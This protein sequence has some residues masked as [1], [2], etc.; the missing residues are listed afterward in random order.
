MKTEPSA[1][2]SA[3]ADIL[4]IEPGELTEATGVGSIAEWDSLAQLAI[5]TT[6]EDEFGLK[7][8]EER[9]ME[10]S[11]VGKILAFVCDE[12]AQAAK[13]PSSISTTKVEAAPPR[14]R[15]ST[16]RS[17][18]TQ[19]IVSSILDRID[20]HPSKVALVFDTESITY[21]Q[22][23]TGMRAA[24]NYLQ[25]KGVCAGDV[26]GL[27]A[28]KQK[29]FFFCY[30]GA[31]LLGATVLNLNPAIKDELLSY[32]QEQT[33]PKL[34]IGSGKGAELSYAEIP[35]H[36]FDQ[37]ATMVSPSMDSVAEIMFTTGT[38]HLPKGVLITHANQAAFT[39]INPY[40]DI[41][42][43]DI[44]LI[45]LPLHHVFGIGMVFRLL[46]TGGT[47]IIARSISNL[48]QIFTSLRDYK[49]TGVAM[50]ASGWMYIRRM[51]GNSVGEFAP[52]LRHMIMA[53]MPVSL[54]LR[55]YL[56]RIFPH[57]RVCV[58]YG[59]TEATMSTIID[60]STETEHPDS[61][62]RG[63]P[64]VEIKICAEDGTELPRGEK[65][66][67]C[68]K[69]PNVM[70]GYLRDQGPG[71]HHG[72]F[73]RSGDWGCMDADG[74]V[75]IIGRAKDIINIGGENV[76]P[77][78]I[79]NVLNTIPGILESACVPTPDPQGIL[80]EV[81]KAIL[82]SDGSTPKPTN[83]QIIASAAKQ[84]DR[85]KLPVV[86]EW[87]EALTRTETGKIQRQLMR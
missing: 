85:F 51:S 80:G 39:L 19:P 27:Y 55:D 81:V 22:L 16:A 83:E 68:I 34:I 71:T 44:E 56:M 86:I 60:L 13:A 23:A 73:L 64:G 59:L 47:A 50:P 76:S 9:M 67:I 66:E 18:E 12:P 36:D 5:V 28:D 17:Y 78:E 20:T 75:Y 72:E 14:G 31:H 6:L 58:A 37:T 26:V 54:E 77:H 2:L 65:G 63:S 45:V 33:N 49:A 8:P 24:A 30:F 53:S 32:V 29:E 57:A 74:Y 69:G 70:K 10:L 38:T 40:V 61:I 15:N 7:I 82:V 3:I 48:P 62:G 84:L 42:D 25:Q 41:T 21:R 35:L 1:I 11:S 4:S 43:E 52:H 79:E 46:V 87:R